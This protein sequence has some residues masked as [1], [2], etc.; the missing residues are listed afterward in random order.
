M[1]PEELLRA[2]IVEIGR[3]LYARGLISG[4]EGNIS[5]RRDDTIFITPTGTCKGFVRPEDIVM[6]DRSG[7][8][9]DRHKASMEMPMHVEIY[10]AR[11]DVSAVVH[12]HPST[13][14]GFAVAGI[15]LDRALTAEAV[16]TLGPVPIVPYGAPGSMDLALAVGRSV[17]GA[18]ALLLA[19]HGALT[20]GENLHRAWERME[21]LEELARITLVTRLLGRESLI[22]P[23]EVERLLALGAVVG[24]PPSAREMAAPTPL[25][26]A[27]VVMTRGELVRLVVAAV[28]HFSGQRP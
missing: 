6:T 1:S 3:R 23:R 4:C 13:A 10:R 27:K 19:N 24:Y 14:T 2:D 25:A 22:P 26:G 28:A 9:L 16:V 11:P 21:T 5:L 18:H 12:A 17:E 8:P 7:R 15:P 20:V